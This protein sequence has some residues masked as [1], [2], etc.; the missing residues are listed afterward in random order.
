MQGL[1]RLFIL[2]RKHINLRHAK[3]F[4]ASYFWKCTKI[5]TRIILC[6]DESNKAGVAMLQTLNVGAIFLYGTALGATMGYSAILLP[7]LQSNTSSIPTDEE[8]GS[9]IGGPKC[10]SHRGV[11]T[12]TQWVI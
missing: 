8:T 3:E 2:A 5:L 4:S 10:N 11:V 1:I 7:Q 6:E 9:W 12:W